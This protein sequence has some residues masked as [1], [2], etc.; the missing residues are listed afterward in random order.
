M[1]D[2]IMERFRVTFNFQQPFKVELGELAVS[3]VSIQ[4][5]LE[6]L[7]RITY[8]EEDL[9]NTEELLCDI[10]DRISTHKDSKE[11]LNNEN[12]DAVTIKKDISALISKLI[13][14]EKDISNNSAD[15]EQIKKDYNVMLKGL[16]ILV[17]VLNDSELDV[18]SIQNNLIM[19]ADASKVCVTGFKR[20][21]VSLLTNW[22]DK[23]SKKFED[24]IKIDND[25]DILNRTLKV[26]F[27]KARIAVANDLMYSF[28]NYRRIFGGETPHY[29]SLCTQ[30]LNEQYN[31][32][33]A[34]L[35]IVDSLWSP[36]TKER[37]KEDF[38]NF[39]GLR[40]VPLLVYDKAYKFFYNE[41]K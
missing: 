9:A 41:L 19:I 1:D 2:K 36:E 22:G 20:T 29:V 17:E 12:K 34:D 40:E 38:I 14:G 7:E 3:D 21:L 25:P 32:N 37:I 28:M 39:I 27:C 8:T 5:V 33:L 35:D 24:K 16:R 11:Y 15:S 10:Q 23:I 30:V 13:K 31:L 4:G 26:L 6:Q 18:V